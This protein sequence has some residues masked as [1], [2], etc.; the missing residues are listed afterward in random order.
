MN[1]EAFNEWK[2]NP[3]TQYFL[4]FLENRKRSI[5]EDQVD[6]LMNNQT[7]PAEVQIFIKGQATTINEIL[8][9]DYETVEAV[10]EPRANQEVQSDS[11][12]GKGGSQTTGY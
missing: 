9:L 11:N 10:N 12:V 4:K 8:D 5:A 3:D 6:K 7:I 1:K 2:E